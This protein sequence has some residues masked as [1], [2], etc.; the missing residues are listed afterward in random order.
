MKSQVTTGYNKHRLRS[1][2]RK[3]EEGRFD[4]YQAPSKQAWD[5]QNDSTKRGDAMKSESKSSADFGFF[6]DPI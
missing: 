4:A 5:L 6:F 2:K 1:R 3:Y